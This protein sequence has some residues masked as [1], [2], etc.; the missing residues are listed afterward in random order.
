MLT[1]KGII[2]WATLLLSLVMT[3]SASMIHLRYAR[4]DPSIGEP[5][6]PEHLRALA[7][8]NERDYYILQ[9][10][11]PIVPS[12]KEEVSKL[13]AELLDYVPDFSFLAR[14]TPEVAKS[15][16]LL[17]MVEA[18]VPYQPAY[19]IDP[20]LLISKQESLVSIQMFPGESTAHVRSEIGRMG[21]L[22]RRVSTGPGGEHIEAVLSYESVKR[23][24]AL[25]GVAWI[26]PRLQRKLKNNV[27]RDIMN[28]TS[29]WTDVGMYGSGE[30]I[31]VCDTGLDTGN[32]STISADFAGRIAKTYALGRKGKWNDPDGHGTHVAGSALGAGV[33]SGANPATHSYIDSFAGIAPEANLIFQSVL[34]NAGGLGGIPSDLN[35][36]FLPPYNDGARIHTN[37]WG[38]DYNGAYPIDSRNLDLFTWNHKDMVILMAAGNEGVDA[39]A[40]GVV[41]LDSMDAPAT[42]KN[43]IAVGATESYRLSGGAQGTYGG[44]WPSDYPADP[45]RNDKVS[46][47]PSGMVAFSSRGPCDDGRIKPDVCAPGTNI[48]SCRSHDPKAGALWGA[49][50]SNYVYC[51]GTS[52]ATP[53]TAGATAL[54]RE[55]YRTVRNHLPSAALVKATLVNS[56]TDIYPGQYGTGSFQEIPTSRPNNIEGWGLINVAYILNAPPSRKTEF[57]D[58]TVGL[59]TNE[60]AVYNYTVAGSNDPLR[61]ALVW[62]DY[63]AATYAATTLV[64]DLD[65]IVTM[66]DGSTRTGNGITDRLNNVE[67][68]DILSPPPGSYTVTVRAYNVPHGPQPFALVVTGNLGVPMPTAEIEL[69]NEGTKVFGPVT[70]TGTAA[71]NGFVLYSLEYGSGPDPQTWTPVMPPQTNPVI[72]GTLGVWDTSILANGTYTLRLKVIGEGGE[73]C[74]TVTVEVLKTSIFDVKNQLDDT[75]V[76][77]TGKIVTAGP[78][79]FDS[80]M[81]VQEPNR[82]CGIRVD[83]GSLQPSVS[84]GSLVTVSGILQT[85]GGERTIL[86][87]VITITGS[88]SAPLPLCM[89]NRDVGGGTL[90]GYVP[91]ITDGVGLNNIGLL[92][93]TWGKVTAVLPDCFYINDGST[94]HSGSGALG[95]KVLTKESL[96]RP[97]VG[98]Y[99][100]VTGISSLEIDSTTYRSVIRPRMASD[101]SIY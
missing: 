89:P 71:G 19:R 87:S 1:R 44:Y 26:E 5:S 18:V 67:T 43:C 11:G 8:S 88:T 37:S 51:G 72:V 9:F 69:P 41:D 36:L 48:I 15:L 38:A 45:I 53:L 70:V 39:N 99:V 65:L 77:L 40:D 63:P 3:C 29:A 55:Y 92:I 10:A 46:N 81:Y 16:D 97:S 96:P 75:P 21:G 4:F 62:T 73:S 59:N 27:A 54:V 74:D 52:M 95:I 42:A 85:V 98:D 86:N 101:V 24:A 90:G 49:Y 22:I 79:E 17:P 34:D 93:R 80:I 6:I 58:N 2:I 30:T 68:V 25:R 13:G 61:V 33:L 83:L 31:A 66:P 100:I 7:A 12:W 32:I 56:A 94:W 60:T 82:S 84:I 91:G 20:D 23:V 50:D 14:M 28:V 76:V 35:Q 78:A 57:V 47:N 64:N